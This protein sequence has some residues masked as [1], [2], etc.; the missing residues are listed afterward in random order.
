LQRG[1][2]GGVGIRTVGTFPPRTVEK[3][4]GQRKPGRIGY[5]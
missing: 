5:C 3:G 2:G 1:R 4:T